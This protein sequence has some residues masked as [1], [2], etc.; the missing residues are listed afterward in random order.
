LRKGR[1]FPL[2]KALEENA[3]AALL[4]RETIGLLSSIELPHWLRL[5]S[6]DAPP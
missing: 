3:P 6:I 5:R 4:L 2:G 1:L